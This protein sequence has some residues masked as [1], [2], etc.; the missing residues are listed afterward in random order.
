MRS[1]DPSTLPTAIPP[2][3]KLHCRKHSGEPSTTHKQAALSSSAILD[4]SHGH[5]WPAA[6]PNVTS[7]KRSR[8]ETPGHPDIGT[9]QPT[10][11]RTEQT[12]ASAGQ[13]GH[14]GQMS[15]FV[16]SVRL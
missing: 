7:A 15:G 11:A 6:K 13:T 4:T 9:K 12:P 8:V 3:S 14:A 5:G 2:E 16:R 10:D 1:E